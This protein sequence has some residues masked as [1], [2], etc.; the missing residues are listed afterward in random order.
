MCE[1]VEKRWGENGS[2]WDTIIESIGFRKVIVLFNLFGTASKEIRNYFF[3]IG[4]EMS[5]EEF[6]Y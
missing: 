4:L 2:L 3:V 5:I 6:V 1:R